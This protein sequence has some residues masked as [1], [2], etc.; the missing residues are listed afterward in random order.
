M[1]GAYALALAKSYLTLEAP[2]PTNISTNYD[3]ETQKN[4][5]PAYPAH[6]LA[7]IVFPV[8]GGPVR[9]APLGILAPI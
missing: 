4:D 3:P 9:R 5:V 7:S 6:A 2:K 1:E 8:P